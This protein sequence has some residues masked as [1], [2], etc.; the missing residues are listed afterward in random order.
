MT[1]DPEPPSLKGAKQKWPPPAT[2]DDALETALAK[3]PNIRT[4][5]VGE[6]ADS[7]GRAYGLSGDHRAWAKTPQAELARQISAGQ[8][9]KPLGAAVD[10][11]A[12]S[13]PFAA[14]GG[15]AVA[16]MPQGAGRVGM[17]AAFEQAREEDFAGAGMPPARPSWL[18]PVIV[19]VAA[20]VLGGGIAL[21][22]A[23]GH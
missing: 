10:P 4:K 15:A 20:L 18:V 8:A 2:L 5:T 19:G 17:D 9:A 16:A 7:I 21:F 12:A 22:A 13:D 1:K 14:P 6:L 23:L 3:N 11:F